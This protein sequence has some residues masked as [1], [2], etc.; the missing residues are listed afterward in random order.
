[1]PL[2][3]HVFENIMENGAFAL[4]G[5]VNH[6]HT[7]TD[8]VPRYVNIQQTSTDRVPRYVNHIPHKLSQIAEIG[9]PHSLHNNPF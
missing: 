3:Y 2:K 8:K 7:S 5:Y 4:L 6:F 9:Q 1:M